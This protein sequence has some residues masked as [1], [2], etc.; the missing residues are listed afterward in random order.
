MDKGIRMGSREKERNR[1][2][3]G[4]NRSRGRPLRV[5][6][7]AADPL[8]LLNFFSGNRPLLLSAVV[9]AVD[10]EASHPFE[11]PPPSGPPW[12]RPL[13]SY[14]S[15]A[16]GTSVL[17]LLLLGIH[18]LY[19]ARTGRLRQQTEPEVEIEKRRA[20][21][22]SSHRPRTTEP[23][24]SNSGRRRRRIQRHSSFSGLGR[25]RF[26]KFVLDKGCR[27]GV[28]KV[29]SR[30]RWGWQRAAKKRIGRETRH[31]SSGFVFSK[32]R[33]RDRVREARR[34]ASGTLALWCSFWLIW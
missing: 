25:Q 2:Y 24:R 22:S 20:R 33:G 27:L 17:L 15:L 1:L 7:I 13:Q 30:E 23:Q 12:E 28:E 16:S 11:K 5:Q 3:P 4:R 18:R 14:P 26:K 31:L 21:E 8:L 32:R 6:L 34:R 9:P 10:R 19:A 29:G